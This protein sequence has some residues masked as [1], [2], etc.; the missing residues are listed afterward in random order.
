MTVA[1]R[2]SLALNGALSALL[3]FTASGA[4]AQAI[5]DPLVNQ[6]F[7]VC[8][9]NGAEAQDRLPGSTVAPSDIPIYFEH[10]VLRSGD[11]HR[12]TQVDGTYAMR[13]IMRGGMD[14]NSILIKCAVASNLTGYDQALASLS[15]VAGTAPRNIGGEGQPRR[16]MYAAADAPYQ[17]FEE[18]DGW[19]SVYRMDVLISARGIDPDYLKEGAQ[20]VPVPTAQ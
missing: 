15:A 17:I 10:D 14:P 11:N 2:K 1:L 9:G 18:A 5:G 13:A 4:S 6:F 7:A 3:A 8:G 12:V 16:A 20:P 19:V